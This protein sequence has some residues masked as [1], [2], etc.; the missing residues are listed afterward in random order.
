MP[1][2]FDGACFE[3]AG[4]KIWEKSVEDIIC[5]F[6]RPCLNSLGGF[7][8]QLEKPIKASQ[9]SWRGEDKPGKAKP[10]SGSKS[11]DIGDYIGTAL[12]A[13]ERRW[14]LAGPPAC[15]RNLGGAAPPPA[16]DSAPDTNR[17]QWSTECQSPITSR[18][19]R[20][21]S[22]CLPDPPC[23]HRAWY[24]LP[25]VVHI[26]SERMVRTSIRQGGSPNLRWG[27]GRL[28]GQVISRLHK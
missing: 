11:L 17:T 23:A 7:G 12:E 1:F 3:L 8:R 9:M 5:S 2:L 13:G 14:C 19:Q 25:V 10:R 28:L 26:S 20:M 6:Q 18:C 4:H 21:G 15:L 24:A 16:V 22:V 27:M